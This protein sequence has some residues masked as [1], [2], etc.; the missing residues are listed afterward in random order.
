MGACNQAEPEFKFN[1]NQI[2][3]YS[4]VLLIKTLMGSGLYQKEMGFGSVHSR[5]TPQWYQVARSFI[6]RSSDPYH[7]PMKP[8]HRL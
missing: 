5:Q 4:K 7:D 6:R 2:D 8:V 1:K 3:H